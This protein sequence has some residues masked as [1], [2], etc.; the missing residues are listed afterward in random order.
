MAVNDTN[1]DAVQFGT[2]TPENLPSLS[3]SDK[4]NLQLPVFRSFFVKDMAVV[5]KRKL[6]FLGQTIVCAKI[7]DSSKPS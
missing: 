2:G 6:G 1:V 3:G 7:D 4:Q 5:C